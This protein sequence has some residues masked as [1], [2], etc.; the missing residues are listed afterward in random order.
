MRKISKKNVEILEKDPFMRE[1][2]VP[3]CCSIPEWHHALIYS[4][5][6]V[7]EWWAIIPLCRL[8]HREKLYFYYDLVKYN[9]M[10]YSVFWSIR[11]ADD[12]GIDLYK[13]YPK[14]NWDQMRKYYN[15]LF[16]NKKI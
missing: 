6:Q 12:A 15:S 3:N 1:C 14:R 13:K 7:D 9:T 11:R 5:R 16:L 2:C 4:G 10:D 8:H